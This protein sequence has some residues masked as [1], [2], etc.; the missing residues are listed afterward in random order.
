MSEALD[1]ALSIT[2]EA[3]HN[4]NIVHDWHLPLVVGAPESG[5]IAVFAWNPLLHRVEIRAASQST[6]D[7]IATLSLDSNGV[8]LIDDNPVASQ[9]GVIEAVAQANTAAAEAASS[10]AAAQLISTQVQAAGTAITAQVA[11]FQAVADASN[12]TAAQLV[13]SATQAATDAA[14]VAAGVGS[15]LAQA[16]A[17]AGTAQTAAAEAASRASANSGVT[18]PD[19]SKSAATYAGQ[20]QQFGLASRL[21]LT[22]PL[23]A[24]NFPETFQPGSLFRRGRVTA[25]GTRVVTI[26]PGIWPGGLGEAWATYRL[27]AAGSLQVLGQA[28]N[29][30]GEIIPSLQQHMIGR[31]RY[32]TLAALQSI[33]R[34]IAVPAVAS[35][36]LV[37][38]AAVGWATVGTVA[39][40]CTLSGGLTPVT[41][42]AARTPSLTGQNPEFA[43][44]DAP[45]TSFAGG[46]IDITLV[47]G[48]DANLQIMAAFVISGQGSGTPIQN[49][50]E[51]TVNTS[52]A[53]CVLTAC[54]ASGLILA[55]AAQ[56][57]ASAVFTS[58]SSNLALLNNG[59]LLS[60]PTANDTDTVKNA[61][62]GYGVGVPPTT[63]DVTVQANFQTAGG[64]AGITA[65]CYPPGTGSIV[66]LVSMTY[67]GGFNTMNV[68]GAEMELW[69]APDGRSVF[70]KGGNA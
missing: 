69:F 33:T 9:A 29:T 14:A 64:G 55:L 52:F 31:Q 15:Q 49:R 27:E 3:V 26:P 10:E 35:G 37:V 25:G 58:F 38:M 16:N 51:N 66:P 18:F 56:R 8:M 5:E 65:I 19:G 40:T 48:P 63:G 1:L 62:W 34:T 61:A 54:P 20:A 22:R 21:A 46:D 6:G 45:L 32:A 28:G 2:S 59:N 7:T 11:A 23:L 43:I 36:K 39:I 42:Q 50:L 44:F 68:V 47:A 13:A 60:V 24:A 17:A 41:R 12:L 67:Q 57:G 4:N 53:S 70:V 30:T